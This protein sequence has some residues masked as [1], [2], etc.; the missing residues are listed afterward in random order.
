MWTLGY[1]GMTPEEREEL[2]DLLEGCASSTWQPVGAI[3]G[4]SMAVT[5]SLSWTS[6]HGLLL[7]MVLMG[8]LLGS[9]GAWAVT[10]RRSSALRNAL[11]RDLRSGKVQVFQVMPRDVVRLTRPGG[12]V[13]GYFAGIGGGQVMF[14][15]PR[16]W[17]HPEDASEGD[18][19]RLFPCRSFSLARA[20]RSKVDLGFTC[21][22]ERIPPLRDISLAS[23]AS[24][25]DWVQDG[26]VLWASLE[27]L[28]GRLGA[29]AV[30][31]DPS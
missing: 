19:E 23:E 22:G 11:R 3:A 8:G 16:E 10:G 24:L 26:D 25:A 15:E 17:E 18:F 13:A 2:R 7:A 29:E 20:P 12:S 4:A 27:T 14:I 31:S 6:D 1:R 9:L 30:G 28:E 21:D 5:A